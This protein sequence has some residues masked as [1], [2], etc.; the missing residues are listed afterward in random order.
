[1]ETRDGLS[2]IE[3]RVRRGSRPDLGRP[4]SSPAENKAAFMAALQEER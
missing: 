4:K 3:V 2:F 1:A